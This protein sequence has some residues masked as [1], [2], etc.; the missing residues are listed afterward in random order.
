MEVEGFDEWWDCSLSALEGKDYQTADTTSMVSDEFWA[1][2]IRA[3]GKSS[4][5]G[6]GYGS[7]T[8]EG[9]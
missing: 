9:Y 5:L 7:G 6:D 4:V 2:E 8:S 3:L 1:K